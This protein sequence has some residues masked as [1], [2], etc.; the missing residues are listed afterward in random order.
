MPYGH[1]PT[2]WKRNSKK[3]EIR[4]SVD[5]TTKRSYNTY[6]QTVVKNRNEGLNM[7]DY[8][9]NDDYKTP[10]ENID[11]CEFFIMQTDRG[12]LYKRREELGMTQQQVADAAKIQL[13][14]YQR[15][16]SGER[17]MAGASLRIALAICH[18]LRLDPYR[19]HP[20]FMG[21]DD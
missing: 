1:T 3:Y 7:F 8:K 2:F 5:I 19:F 15:L 13:R 9:F 17:T 14:Q 10:V 6:D 20:D 4:F 18:V 21:I 12:I 11:G 16:E